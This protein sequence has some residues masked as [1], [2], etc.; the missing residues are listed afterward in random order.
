MS[1]PPPVPLA[2]RSEPLRTVAAAGALGFAACVLAAFSLIDVRFGTALGASTAILAWFWL[3]LGARTPE[4]A[5]GEKIYLA[6]LSPLVRLG[7]GAAVFGMLNGGFAGS[8]M[9]IAE[10]NNDGI[11]NIILKILGG[12]ALGTTFGAMIWIPAATVAFLTYGLPLWWASSKMPSKR[13]DAVDASLRTAHGIMVVPA[14]F[15]FFIALAAL[16]QGLGAAPS[17]PEHAPGLAHVLGTLLVTLGAILVPAFAGAAAHRRL[18]VR[19][20]LLARAL[21]GDPSVR[22]VPISES[23][24]RDPD[25]ATVGPGT[26]PTHVL[27]RISPNEA[28]YRISAETHEELA[29]YCEAAGDAKHPQARPA[30]PAR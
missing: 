10:S 2:R 19:R 3:R 4:N 18:T 29:I 23:Q 11:N 30:M 24:L 15:A 7:I 6:K 5:P 26:V 27:V 22:L 8:A 25:A 21:D 14:L 12:F 17:R 20:A 16:G 9:L 28:N 1:T 13:A